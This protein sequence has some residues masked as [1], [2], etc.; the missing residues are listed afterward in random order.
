MGREGRPLFSYLTPS[1]LPLS[2]S[3]SLSHQVLAASCGG[4]IALAS[5]LAAL[6]AF[7]EERAAAAGA[8]VVTPSLRRS[9]KRD[10]GGGGG[11]GGGGAPASFPPCSPAEA[12]DELHA[13]LLARMCGVDV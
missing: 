2:L 4:P 12:L 10:E 11:G 5:R 8:P 1:P 7:V 6:Q 13:H 9:Q 3:L